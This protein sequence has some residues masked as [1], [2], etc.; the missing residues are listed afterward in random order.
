MT[1]ED[2]YACYRLLLGRKPDA[3]GLRI[4]Q[5][6]VGAV[7]FQ[8]IVRAL[9]FAPEF[10]QTQLYR[11]LVNEAS[12]P[13]AEAVQLDG[14]SIYIRPGDPISDL[15]ARDRQY[16][17][18]VTRVFHKHLKPGMTFI[19]IGANIGF[20]TLLAAHI[21]GKA[22]KVFAFEPNPLNCL[23]LGKSVQA[24]QWDHVRLYPLAA[25]ARAALYLYT[26][27]VGSNGQIQQL[28]LMTETTI[29]PRQVLVG[30]DTL[31]NLIPAGTRPH[32]IKIDVEGAEYL[33]IQGAQKLLREH[34]PLLVI[35]YTPG[36]LATISQIEGP[37]FLRTLQQLGYEFQGIQL[38]GSLR[39]FGSDI[40]A[41]HRWCEQETNGHVDFLATPLNN[42]KHER[43]PWWKISQQR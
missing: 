22:G 18:N 20:F 15:I 10:Q 25:A 3:D 35:E 12:I 6:M 2:I 13:A 33:V 11:E 32:L 39:P 7:P 41:L 17:P 38:D 29:Q 36:A 40:M 5:P 21:V 24:N 8:T 28:D 1:E 4:F 27:L 43:R 26:P 16:E 30:G 23:T 34:R 14:Y 42:V 37:E 19:D 9:L 31:D